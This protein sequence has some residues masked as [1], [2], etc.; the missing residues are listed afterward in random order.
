MRRWDTIEF[1]HVALGPVPEI[2][3]AINVIMTVGKQL[4]MVDAEVV[5]V[6]YIQ[7]IV[8]KTYIEH[9]RLNKTCFRGLRLKA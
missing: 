5:E 8:P 6:R 3:N 9:H 4:G 2:L 1:A 7:H